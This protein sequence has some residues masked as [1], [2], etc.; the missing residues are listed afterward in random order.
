MDLSNDILVIKAS[1]VQLSARVESLELENAALRSENAALRSRLNLNSKN[2][3]KPPSSDGLRKRP[4][5]TSPRGK[6]K[7]WP[8]G[9]QGQDAQDGGNT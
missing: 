5:L 9:A 4:G 2:S 7:R 3:H 1:V 8:G 6:E